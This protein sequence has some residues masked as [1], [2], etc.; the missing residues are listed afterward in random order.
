MKK[1]YW[2]EILNLQAEWRQ[3]MQM[4]QWLSATFGHKPKLA[5]SSLLH[6]EEAFSCM[7][8]IV[9]SLH[10]GEQPNLDW[11]EKRL[12]KIRP[13]VAAEKFLCAHIQT[14]MPLFHAS[15][16]GQTDDDILNAI[17]NT[18]L[19]QFAQFIGGANQNNQIPQICR[20]QGI[21]RQ[22]GN[23][24]SV[25]NQSSL[26]KNELRWRQELDLLNE[27]ALTQSPTIE[28]CADFFITSGKARFCSDACRFATFQFSKHLE[29]PEYHAEKQKRYRN[30]LGGGS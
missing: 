4:W 27:H 14:V 15:I 23:A 28:R 11:L 10:F 21:V 20:C 26:S 1:L 3:E 7:R 19:L 13:S 25:E 8:E 9:D 17:T 12:D 22:F 18:L 29:S 24:E 5:P 30:K 6:L 16:A 2:L